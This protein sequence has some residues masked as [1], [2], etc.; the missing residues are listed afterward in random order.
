MQELETA[1][2][3]IKEYENQS[4][5][6]RVNAFYGMNLLLKRLLKLPKWIPFEYSTYIEHSIPYDVNN[7]EFIKKKQKDLLLVNTK[8]RK[9]IIYN[10]L[11]KK[12]YV[13]GPLFVHYRRINNIFPDPD[14]TGTL[15]FPVHSTHLI[16]SECNWDEYAE[17]LLSLDNK[18][19]PITICFY[20]KNILDG[21][22]LPFQKRGFKITTAGHIY[23]PNFCINF[24][25]LL[26]KYKF[27]SSNKFASPIVYSLE[28][29]IP[30][31]H[32]GPESNYKYYELTKKDD[33]TDVENKINIDKILI[34]YYK[35]FKL[36]DIPTINSS[37]LEWLD[38]FIDEKNWEDLNFIRK[39]VYRSFFPVLI[40]KLI[41][42]LK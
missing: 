27:T 1:I 32:Y 19:K 2:S 20:W 16:K 5:S 23:D 37:Q 7:I 26:R 28:M 11:N 21:D 9:K 24:Y 34:E 10:S 39:K 6:V 12:S 22:H 4:K 33:F 40:K 8:E 42:F 3:R 18:F 14:R 25:S 15:V 17:Q 38:Q 35:L 41:P 29:G 30:H 31:F 13:L 36:N